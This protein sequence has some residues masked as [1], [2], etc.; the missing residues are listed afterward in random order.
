MEIKIVITKQNKEKILKLIDQLVEYEA[1]GIVGE[2]KEKTIF[3]PAEGCISSNFLSELQGIESMNVT[4]PEIKKSTFGSWGMFNSYVPGKAALRVLINLINKNDGKPVRFSDLVD[5]CIAYFSKSGLYM[6]RGFPKK[7]SESA[8]GRLAMHLISPYH[9]MGLMRVNDDKRDPYVMIT[10]EGFTFAKLQNPLLDGGDKTKSLSEEESRWLMSHLK[11][12]E[13][14][15]YME[16]SVLQNLTHF[17]AT[18]NRRFEDIV[19]WFK[20]NQNFVDWLKAGSRYKDDPKAFS[21]Q[22]QNV[23]RTFA[24]GK[25]ALLR[26]LGVLTTSRAKYH[27]LR[28]LEV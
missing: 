8:R 11:T 16:F 7:A 15:G 21:F 25:I 26:E 2:S 1:E 22:L 5:E 17:L 13:E 14:Q 27:V 12:I 10:Q 28:S 6:Y 9:K 18:E 23:A 20:N 4:K 19:D 24:T 3:E